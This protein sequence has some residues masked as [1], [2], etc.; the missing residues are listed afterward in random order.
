MQLED[1]VFKLTI[2]NGASK[3]LCKQLASNVFRKG[4][5]H[6]ELD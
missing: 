6:A 1:D 2:S 5:V 3:Q 4:L